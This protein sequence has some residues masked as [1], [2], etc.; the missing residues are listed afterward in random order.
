MPSR[1]PLVAK[2]LRCATRALSRPRPL[3]DKNANDEEP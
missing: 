3:R 1:V 2:Q